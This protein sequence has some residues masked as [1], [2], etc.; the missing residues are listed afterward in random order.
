MVQKKGEGLRQE[1]KSR[2]RRIQEETVTEGAAKESEGGKGEEMARRGVRRRE[3]SGILSLRQRARGGAPGDTSDDDA[4][5]SIGSVLADS[6]VAVA[7]SMGLCGPA[8]PR[9]ASPAASPSPPPSPRPGGGAEAA[10]GGLEGRKRSA[11]PSTTRRRRAG[12]VA[13]S[14][15]PLSR[16]SAPPGG[17]SGDCGAPSVERVRRRRL[18]E[19]P[20]TAG[21]AFAEL[22]MSVS[23]APRGGMASGRSVMPQRGAG[24]GARCNDLLAL[25]LAMGWQEICK[26]TCAFFSSRRL[27]ADPVTEPNVLR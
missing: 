9:A 27:L 14:S 13:P 23:A 11:R 17:G 12:V 18:A 10:A 5:V 3:A 2:G 22:D 20:A 7:R 15:A 19:R 6:D 8:Q 25:L 24:P 1:G 26:G 4:P 21:L 16:R